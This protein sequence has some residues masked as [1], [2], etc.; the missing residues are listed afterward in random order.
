[1]STILQSAEQGTAGV[2]IWGDHHSEATKTDC[3]EIKNYIDNFLGPL[4]KSITAIAQ[5][6]SQEFCNLHGRCK[7]QLNPDL[8]FKASSLEVNLHFLS[9][10]WKFLSCRCHSGW[11][12]EDCRH[13]LL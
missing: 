11:S 13:H 5:N 12:G 2:V 7:F 8:Y 4:V 6:C 10:Q 1:M 9:D 3:I